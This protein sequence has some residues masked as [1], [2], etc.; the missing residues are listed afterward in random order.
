M[1]GEGAAA[2]EF[3]LLGPLEVRRDGEALPL[4][5]P[6]QA[7][8]L[9][10]LLL[11]PNEVVPRARLVDGLWGERP[12]ASVA[13]ALQ[14]AAHALRKLLGRERLET[15]GD[16]YLLRVA[17][18]EVDLQRA[19]A[20]LRRARD[21]QE[22][23]AAAALLAE[24]L[25]LWRGPPLSGLREVPFARTEAPRLDELRLVVLERRL[26]AQL[27]AGAGEELVPELQ[28]LV[29]EQPYRER[30][31]RHLMLAL[32][33]AGRQAEALA[34][35]RSARRLLVD[36]LGVEP[37]PELRELERRLLR[38]DPTLLPPAP[39]GAASL[40]APA[41]RLIGRELEIAAVTS[42]IRGGAR[43]LT[44]TG[45]GGT[46]KTRLGLAAAQALAESFPDGV[47]FVPLAP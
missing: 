20:L 29:A 42:L 40:P 43:L 39:S 28:A 11:H 14:V 9:A 12:P 21:E 4:P 8:L 31:H 25:A 36:D 15:R 33:R 23:A 30:L 32:Y 3:R 16:G 13:N 2:L 26:A 46:G 17:A 47:W 27:D 7:A 41:T 44:L 35:F 18:G 45:P 1:G 38:H 37:G 24:A 5:G 19:E 22:P 6:R 34:A 10:L